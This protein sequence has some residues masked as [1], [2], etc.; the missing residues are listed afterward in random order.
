MM[1]VNNSVGLTMHQSS[2]CERDRHKM[3]ANKQD[4]RSYIKIA[5]LRGRNAL[6]CHAELREALGVYVQ[7]WVHPS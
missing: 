7:R 1:Y 6:Q 3:E 4:Q 5:V 2:V